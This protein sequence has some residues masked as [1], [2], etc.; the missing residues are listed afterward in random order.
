MAG[1]CRMSAELLVR[2]PHH[3]LLQPLALSVAHLFSGHPVQISSWVF[4]S[5]CVQPSGITPSVYCALLCPPCYRTYYL[6]PIKRFPCSVLSLAFFF[7]F[8]ASADPNHCFCLGLPFLYFLTQKNS[9]S[10]VK[11]KVGFHPS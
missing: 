3:V 1:V 8:F 2:P 11:T 10:S 9:H 4:W 5:A 7:S 6:V